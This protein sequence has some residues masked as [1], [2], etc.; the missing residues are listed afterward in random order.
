LEFYNYFSSYTLYIIGATLHV[1][2]E[3]QIVYYIA[4]LRVYCSCNLFTSV[5]NYLGQTGCMAE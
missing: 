3:I 5:I 2:Q 1:D 4:V